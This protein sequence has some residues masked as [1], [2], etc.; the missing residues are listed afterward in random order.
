MKAVA[1]GVVAVALS[2]MLL[3][4]CQQTGT[5][6]PTQGQ[7][8]T[9]DGAPTMDSRADEQAAEAQAPRTRE[10]LEDLWG[11][12]DLADK[13]PLDDRAGDGGRL[14]SCTLDTQADLTSWAEGA[15]LRVSQEENLELEAQQAE[16]VRTWLDAQ[17]YERLDVPVSDPEATTYHRKDGFIVTVANQLDARVSLDVESPC[18]D[19]D[20]QAVSGT[21]S[22]TDR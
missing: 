22:R 21:P 8:P 13:L 20:G 19:E 5:N 7:S 17:D 14:R 12:F 9:T 4:G 6:G 10:I 1:C 11:E 16:L 15:G 3:A 2:G 18:F